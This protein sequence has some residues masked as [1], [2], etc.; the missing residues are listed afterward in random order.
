MLSNT[1]IIHRMYDHGKHSEPEYVYEHVNVIMSTLEFAPLR[2]AAR[3]QTLDL[4]TIAQ[5]I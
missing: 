5:F 4:F 3:T 1:S 2:I